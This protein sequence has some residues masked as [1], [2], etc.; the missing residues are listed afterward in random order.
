MKL[1]PRAFDFEI[2]QL[3]FDILLQLVVSRDIVSVYVFG[4]VRIIN[5]TRI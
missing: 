3:H 5:I 1:T 4:E 2:V